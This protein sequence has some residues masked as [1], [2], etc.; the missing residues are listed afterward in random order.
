MAQDFLHTARAEALEPERMAELDLVSL[1]EQ[2]ADELYPVAAAQGRKI[3][4]SLPEDPV[5]IKGDFA[6]LERCAINLLQNALNYAPDGEAIR[7]E[8]NTSGGDTGEVRFCVVN[9][10]REFSVQERRLLFQR[11]QRGDGSAGQPQGAGLG[12]YFV[13]TVAEKHGGHAD[14]ECRDGL[15]CF[16]V[17]L[18][19]MKCAPVVDA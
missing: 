17:S 9:S 14:V 5:W 11:Y 7:L 4:R 16:R 12:L 19:A 8:V 10:G 13:R 1:L 2:A 18:P 6:A 15:V 3:L